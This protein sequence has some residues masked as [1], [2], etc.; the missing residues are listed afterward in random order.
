VPSDAAALVARR[1]LAIK[2]ADLGD[3]LLTLPALRLVRQA[4]P[5]ARLDVLTTPRGRDVYGSC[6]GL[7]DRVHVLEKH[8]FDGVRPALGSTAAALRLGRAL[9]AAR[10]D[11]ALLLHT[12]PTRMGALKHASL[13][14]AVG[15]PVRIGLVRGGSRRGWFLTHPV[16]DRGY[17]GWHVADAMEAVAREICRGSDGSGGPGAPGA[18]G[19]PGGSDGPGGPGGLATNRL[20]SF[21]SR[22]RTPGPGVAPI[23]GE[24]LAEDEAV[25]GQADALLWPLR[26]SGTSVDRDL[27]ADQ[28]RNPASR[29]RRFSSAAQAEHAD[30]KV[31]G[32]GAGDEGRAGQRRHR[33]ARVPEVADRGERGPLVAMHPGTGSY[34]PSRR[35][36]AEKFAGVADLLA[37]AGITTVLLGTREDGADRVARACLRARPLDLSGRTPLP[38]LAAVLRRVDAYLGNDSGVTHLAATVGAAVV[39]LFGPTSA[40]AWGPQ[41]GTAAV[42]IVARRLPCR[43]C[44]YV[45]HGLGDPAGCRT[46]DC[47]TWISPEQVADV[48]LALLGS[49]ARSSAAGESGVLPEVEPA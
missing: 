12:L 25:A 37:D 40:E 38:V 20:G 27:D 11:A 17:G 36:P 31:A 18:P 24:P 9:R 14:L 4:Y 22:V 49:S 15:A 21:R 44:L 33:P 23:W 3:A 10:Y 43:P 47:L 29:P 35:W 13:M 6:G 48:L 42:R 8:G 34:A 19:A 46:R 7:V 39:A 28:D 30:P 26:S 45:G 16:A 1:I 32:R 41:S 5:E 2:L